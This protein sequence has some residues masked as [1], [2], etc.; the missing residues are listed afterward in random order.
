MI[1][2]GYKLSCI[3]DT[4]RNVLANPPG[5]PLSSSGLAQ[6]QGLVQGMLARRA[7]ALGHGSTGNDPSSSSSSSSSLYAAVVVAVGPVIGRLSPTSASVLME[8]TNDGYAELRCVDQLSGVAH[9]CQR[10]VFARQPMVFLFDNLS[11]NRGYDVY[12]AAEVGGGGLGDA[13]VKNAVYAML[14]KVTNAH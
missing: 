3:T 14:P 12:L 5:N 11:P 4:L 7:P 2:S 1:P 8:F 6:G 10:R 9:C 13:H